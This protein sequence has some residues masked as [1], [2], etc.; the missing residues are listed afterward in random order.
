[1]TY[2]CPECKE[3]MHKEFARAYYLCPRCGTVFCIER[4]HVFDPT[5][6]KLV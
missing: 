1:M 3:A 5:A 2:Y 4:T 6:Q